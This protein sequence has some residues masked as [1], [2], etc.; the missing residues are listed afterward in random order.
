MNVGLDSAPEVAIGSARNWGHWAFERAAWQ[1]AAT[2]YQ[3]VFAAVD[4]LLRE[5]VL[6]TGK[7]SWLREAQGLA[8]RAAY[9]L[10]RDGRPEQAVV[11]LEQGRV[12]LLAEALE[13]TRRDLELL[14]QQGHADAYRRFRDA[15]ETVQYLQQPDRAGGVPAGFD[16]HQAIQAAR[17]ELDAAI[18]AIRAIAGFEDF[19]VAPSW[20]RIQRA[21]SRRRRWCTWSRRRPAAWR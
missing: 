21:V 20:E 17:V 18:T 2:A 14:P 13:H 6:R 7:E 1:E 8:G 10:A 9:A 16:R 11:A 4:R 12:R 15:A 19:L 3:G 5:Q